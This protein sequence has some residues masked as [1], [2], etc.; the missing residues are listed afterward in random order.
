MMRKGES[1]LIC[2]N[3]HKLGL[4]H[5][6]RLDVADEF[7]YDTIEVNGKLV[8]P[9][10]ETTDP[11]TKRAIIG[12]M[13]IRVTK[14]AV[15]ALGIDFDNTFLAQG[16][17]RPDLIESGNPLVSG[18]AN[19]IKTHHNDVDIVRAARDRGMIIETNWDWHK[20]EVR[21]VARLLGLDEEIASRQPFPG[22]GLGVRIICSNAGVT[23]KNSAD[24]IN[25]YI[26][27]RYVGTF[28][29]AIA[30]IES[31]GVQ[32]DHRSYK[33]LC[34]LSASGNRSGSEAAPDFEKIFAL[35]R[36][37][38]NNFNY[39]NR[40]AFCLAGDS[41]IE[42]QS[43]DL[44]VNENS[45]DLLR[46][47]DAVVTG[48]VMNPKISQCFAVLIPIGNGTAKYSVAIRAVV[49]RDFMTASP[50]MPGVHVDAAALIAAAERIKG[51]SSDIAA[52]YYDVTGKP[53]AT[54]EW[55]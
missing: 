41:N 51:L 39:I 14:A 1:D 13:F 28:A 11:E 52:V 26:A 29:A 10:S 43:S 5:M 38:P 55:E 35:A 44:H 3:L 18:H 2:E 12:S 20:D 24:D 40:V 54:V 34:L 21:R 4:L 42:A 36:E 47:V 33:S 19:K 17:L 49:T 16:T 32:G 37:I 50:A 25:N 45:T 9:L 30:P 27:S 31:V 53:P 15:D 8:G 46:E 7:F 22:P 48:S 6:K 23:A